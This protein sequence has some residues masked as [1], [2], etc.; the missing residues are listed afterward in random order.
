VTPW[1]T[2]SVVTNVNQYRIEVD[3]LLSKRAT[4]DVPKDSTTKDV[5][6]ILGKRIEALKA[7]IRKNLLQ[8]VKDDVKTAPT[9]S[10]P[11]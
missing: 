11:T 10:K 7:E 8:E 3:F 6:E 2:R 9:S 4:V 5:E 1:Q